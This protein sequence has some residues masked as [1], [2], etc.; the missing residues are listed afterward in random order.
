MNKY[1]RASLVVTAVLALALPAHGDAPKPLDSPIHMTTL[2]VPDEF[3]NA[4]AAPET[5]RMTEES[6]E[7]HITANAPPMPVSTQS[8][9][10]R[11][12]TDAD[13]SAGGRR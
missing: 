8:A 1:T 9:T 12:D 10:N 11:D 5:G 13:L 7:S 3:R 2:P 6:E 4:P